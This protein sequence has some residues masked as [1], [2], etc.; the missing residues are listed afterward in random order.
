MLVMIDV[1]DHGTPCRTAATIGVIAPSCQLGLSFQLLEEDGGGI[2]T[3][4]H[5]LH[6]LFVLLFAGGVPERGLEFPNEFVPMRVSESGAGGI[7]IVVDPKVFATMGPPVSGALD[8]KGGGAHYH[9]GWYAAEL[10]AERFEVGVAVAYETIH[11]V[12]V[13]LEGFREFHDDRPCLKE[14]RGSSASQS[15]TG[16]LPGGAH[17]GGRGIEYRSGSGW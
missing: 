7:T 5:R 8:E 15:P 6:R 9:E 1:N 2:V 11:V 4:L 16:P 14:G 3:H 10:V 13:S 12:V 17:P